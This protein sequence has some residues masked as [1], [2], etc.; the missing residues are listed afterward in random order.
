MSQKDNLTS[1]TLEYFES[2]KWHYEVRQNDDT[3][4]IAAFG[5]NLKGRLSSCRV[6]T[7][8][9]ERDIQCLTV[10]PIKATE[11]VRP[12]VAEY[13]TRANYG[14]KI[15]KFEMDMNDG[16]VRY[17]AIL[18]CSEGVPSIKDVE[19]IIDMGFLMF[20]RF[21]DGLIKNLMG[22]GNPA[23]DIKAVQ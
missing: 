8:V 23:E 20:Q 4:F 21:G 14:M 5:I 9:D 2:Q 17:Q 6:L 18:P 10:C 13:L 16:E 7:I 19:R 22:F 12:Q 15:G 1:V 3:R 11:D